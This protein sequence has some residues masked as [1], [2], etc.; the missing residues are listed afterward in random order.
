MERI[1]G[2]DIAIVKGTSS[3]EGDSENTNEA[4]SYLDFL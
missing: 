4:M 2:K 3:K 1:N